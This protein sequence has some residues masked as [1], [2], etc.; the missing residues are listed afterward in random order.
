MIK[1]YFDAFRRVCSPHVKEF[2]VEFEAYKT[3]NNGDQRPADADRFVK[4]VEKFG[5]FAST[6]V[7]FDFFHY[8]NPH[9]HLKPK[10]YQSAQKKLYEAVRDLAREN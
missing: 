3:L 8:M 1:P 6:R 2:W 9:G 4:Q 10:D 5:A 7:V